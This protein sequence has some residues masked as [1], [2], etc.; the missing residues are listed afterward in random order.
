MPP[1]VLILSLKSID[2]RD[3]L[4]HHEY[5]NYCTPVF[6][7]LLLD[8]QSFA[9]CYYTKVNVLTTFHQPIHILLLHNVTS[10]P[11]LFVF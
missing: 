6:L 10:E 5:A 9:M 7:I 8:I 1:R 2:V 3:V 11:F 4:Y